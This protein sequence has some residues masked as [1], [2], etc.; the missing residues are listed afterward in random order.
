VLTE[1]CYW[2]IEKDPNGET[3]GLRIVLKKL[4]YNWLWVAGFKEEER[5]NFPEAQQGV[6]QRY[7]SA[8]KPEKREYKRYHRPSL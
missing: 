1:D 6:H 2:D 4:D 3:N 7:T 8:G 5:K